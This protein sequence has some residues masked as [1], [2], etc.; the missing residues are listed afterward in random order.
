MTELVALLRA[1]ES[2]FARCEITM[3][4]SGR[5]VEEVAGEVLGRLQAS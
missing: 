3:E 5:G 1:R 4:T 2:R